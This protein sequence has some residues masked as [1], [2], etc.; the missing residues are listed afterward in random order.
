MK[1]GIDIDGV[2]TNE[3][4]Y[5]LD[6]TTKY[7]YENKLKNY[8]DANNYETRKFNW[9]K[10]ILNDYREKYFFEYV[11]NYP[12]RLYAKEIINKLKE[13]K[14]T[15]YIITSRH[16]SFEKNEKGN[17]MRQHIKKWLNKNNIY[18][19]ELYFFKDK[20]KESKKLNL[21][22]MIE[23]S[24]ETIPEYLKFV[25]VF[26]YDCRYN[27]NLKDKNLTRVYSWYDIYI[28]IKKLIENEIN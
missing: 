17:Q 16:L 24:P 23:D 6:T 20:V 10:E 12:P 26:C 5:L 27:Q 13:E 14:H 18:Y 11:K 25:K 1:I 2:L 7:C 4:E 28:K 15:I 19:D 3:D 21:D 8:I 22:L 9:S